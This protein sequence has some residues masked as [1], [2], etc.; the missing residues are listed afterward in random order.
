V[1]KNIKQMKK[2]YI[3][4]E[5]GSN[6]NGSMKIAKKTIL[7]A[8]EAGA[9][10]VKF[11]SFSPQSLFTK[12]MLNKNLQLKKE[13][14]KYSLSPKKLEILAGF[15]KKKSIDFASTPFSDEELNFLT[16]K[17]KVK[18]IKIASMDLNNYQ[19]LE[20]VAKTKK[21]VF[22]STG[23]AKYDEIVRAI[24]IFRKHGSKIVLLH[25]VAM[26]PADKKFLNLKKILL[27]KQKFKC[28]IGYS[29][30]SIG[31]YACITAAALGAKVI[32]KHFTLDKKMA[33]WDHELSADKEEL[34][35]IINA[36]KD[37]PNM[38]GKKTFKIVES[39]QQI[40]AF[41]R[42][43]V[44]KHNLKKG[45]IIKESDL[46]FKRPGNGLSPENMKKLI[47]KKLRH[48]I[49]FD[50]QLKFKNF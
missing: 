24:K 15:C 14:F 34:K 20:K 27:L 31:P 23:M 2:P 7:K 3:I 43:I 13:V 29:D 16:K 36:C 18:F 37:I 6:H 8:I 47:G 35:N 11:Q 42:S 28:E 1:L 33:G 22:I 5:I 39:K 17:I 38:L 19:F 32:E 12:D 44:A 40:K 25:C 10:C 41:R 26:Y 4:A 49:N 30:H 21:T 48:N 45:K 46:D 50:Q 9:D